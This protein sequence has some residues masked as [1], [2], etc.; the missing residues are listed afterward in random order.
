MSGDLQLDLISLEATMVAF[1]YEFVAAPLSFFC[2]RELQATFFGQCRRKFGQATPADGGD[3]ID[4]FRHEY[5]TLWRYQRAGD[6]FSE[7]LDGKGRAGALDFAILDR[8]FVTQSDRLVVIN[9]HDQRRRDL[10]RSQGGKE[11]SS[12]IAVGIEF[13]MIHVA[14]RNEP[15]EAAVRRLRRGLKEDCR[16]LG[17]EAPRVAYMLAFSHSRTVADAATMMATAHDEF[18]RCARERGAP[19]AGDLRIAIVAREATYVRG[20]WQMNAFPALQPA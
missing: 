6:A 10:R 11:F 17:H 18:S 19:T 5:N 12:A 9:K 4:L 7:R 13:K 1:A 15:T 20:L 2:E 8:V 3:S 16:K 14:A